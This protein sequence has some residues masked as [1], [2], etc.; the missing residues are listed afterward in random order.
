MNPRNYLIPMVVEQEGNGERSYDIYSRL[1]KDRVIIL[2][3]AIDENVAS[4]LIAQVKYLN[5]QDPE[6]PIE[7]VINSPGG[8]VSAGLAIY[9]IMRYGIT[10]PIRTIC[11]GTAASMGAFLLAAGTKGMRMATPNADIMIHQVSGGVQ[12]T[13]SDIEIQANQ[14][15]KTKKRLNELLA[16]FTGKTVAEVEAASDRDHYMSAQEALDFGIIDKI[17]GQA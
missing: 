5:S 2:S 6:K 10:A 14:I 15:L 17:L 11:T 16:D 7:I 1:L 3:S 4:I 9:D 13:G 8:Y 12:G